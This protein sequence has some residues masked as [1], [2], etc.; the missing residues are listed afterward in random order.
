M[1]S[2]S[3]VPSIL[4][5]TSYLR[6]LLAWHRISALLVLQK[7]RVSMM[8]TVSKFFRDLSPN[9]SLVIN[10]MPQHLLAAIEHVHAHLTIIKIND[11]S[12]ESRSKECN[13]YS[14]FVQ[15]AEGLSKSDFRATALYT[16]NGLLT[17]RTTKIYN[18][19]SIIHTTFKDMKNYNKRKHSDIAS[20]NNKSAGCVP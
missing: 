16:I 5:Y 13:T 15:T 10:L 6:W 20:S 9:R 3:I 12:L 19:I 11:F 4:L 8:S 1:F 17:C 14:A 7:M 18:D 2:V